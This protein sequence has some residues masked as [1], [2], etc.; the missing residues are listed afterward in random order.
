MNVGIDLGTTY[1]LVGCW[2]NERVCLVPDRLDTR[3]VH[4]PS[5]V[6]TRPH[7]VF[8]GRPAIDVLTGGGA[9]PF[10]VIKRYLATEETFC[11]ADG[12]RWPPEALCGFI[13]RKLVQD[14]TA[15]RARAG[16]DGAVITV[17]ASFYARQREAVRQAAAIAGIRLIALLEEPV[18]AAIHYG[19][20]ASA[21]P[22]DLLVFD[23]GGGTFDAAVV[24][25][26]AATRQIN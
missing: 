26:S 16:V 15:W 6:V 12:R 10:I 17:P 1:S 7:G 11:D 24:S 19:F 8:V 2:D 25:V 14:A 9:T 13:L 21:D 5:V 18:A 22:A 4:T 3:L 20:S 23:W